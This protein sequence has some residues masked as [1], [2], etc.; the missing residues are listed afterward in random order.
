MFLS[1]EEFVLGGFAI[2]NFSMLD[3]SNLRSGKNHTYWSRN[4]DFI[5]VAASES[6]V[7]A[8]QSK[9][10]MIYLTY[11][12][13]FS[14]RL[15]GLTCF[16]RRRRDYIVMVVDHDQTTELSVVALSKPIQSG[17][18]YFLSIMYILGR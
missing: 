9:F 8:N 13:V 17:S 10:L 7:E 2:I 5:I 3:I 18:G 6:L 16:Q 1:T 15:S 11:F 12:T 4:H 14:I